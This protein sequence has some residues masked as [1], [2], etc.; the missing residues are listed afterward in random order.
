MYKKLTDEEKRVIE[1]KGTQAPFVGKYND[2]YEEGIYRCKKCGSSLYKSEDKFEGH[3]GHV[4]EGEGFTSKDTRHCVNSISLDFEEKSQSIK[5]A[6]FAGGC[7]WGIE[8]LFEKEKGVIKAISGY[9][10]GDS[11]SANYEAVCTGTTSHLEAVEIEYDENIVTYEYLVKLFFEIHDFTQTNGQ[12]PDIGSQYLSAIFY[13]T[14]EEKDICEKIIKQLKSLGYKV[15]TKLYEKV[16]FY[17]AEQYH[18]NYYVKHN[19][20]PYCHSYK[21]IFY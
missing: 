18:Q 10:G 7:F 1:N 2:F 5:H 3:L 17:E 21:K 15:A 12:G 4:F 16:P 13:E 14:Q 11:N 6:Y 20:L 19:K 9:M 8:Y